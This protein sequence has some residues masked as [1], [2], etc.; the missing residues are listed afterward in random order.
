[1]SDRF[2]SCTEGFCCARDDFQLHIIYCKKIGY[3]GDHCSTRP[4]SFDCPCHDGLY[5]KPNIAGHLHSLYGTCRS[6][7][8]TNNVTSA[9]TATTSKPGVSLKLWNNT[10]PMFSD[11]TTGGITFQISTHQQ[12]SEPSTQDGHTQATSNTS[13]QDGHGQTT[14]KT[15]TQD[16]HTQATSNTSTQDG[17]GQTTSKTSTQDGHTQATSNTS[18]NTQSQFIG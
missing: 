17:H 7:K 14:S 13:T 11:I 8:T 10:D 15:S 16:G 6:D 5:C 4:S 18:R 12:A 2:E 9:T 3:E 1:M